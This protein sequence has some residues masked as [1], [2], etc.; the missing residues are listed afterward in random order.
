MWYF[1]L[2]VSPQPDTQLATQTSG[3]FVNCWIDFRE[4]DGAELLA[5]FYL[6]QEGW[7]Y[8]ETQ[9]ACWVEKSD[10][11]DDSEGLQHFFDAETN[12]AC[13][14]VNQWGANGEEEQ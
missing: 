13:L 5:K 14:V 1:I 6:A 10:Y 4:R 8:D 9:E 12:S 2:K 3:A 11:D 7:N